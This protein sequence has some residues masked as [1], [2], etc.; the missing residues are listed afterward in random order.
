MVDALADR[1]TIR[2]LPPLDRHILRCRD[3]N[4]DAASAILG[5]ALPRAAC[6]SASQGD[7]SALWLGPDEWLILGQGEAGERLRAAGAPLAAIGAAF[8]DVGH[9][10]KAIVIAGTD[11]ESCLASGCPL[12]LAP[13]AFPVGACTRTLFHKAEIIVWRTG[14]SDFHIA[15]WRSFMP[16]VE[17]LLIGE[18]ES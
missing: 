5:L 13:A 10:Q 7:S 3:A 9:R 18:C 2:R 15:V 4:I 1:V 14:P 8:V 12:D 11:V 17:A 16:Y 6:G